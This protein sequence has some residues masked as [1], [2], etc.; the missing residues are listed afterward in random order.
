MNL[1]QMPMKAFFF[2]C[3]V[4]VG[5]ASLVAAAH[6]RTYEIASW[7]VDQRV[8][9]LGGGPFCINQ[10]GGWQTGEPQNMYPFGKDVNETCNS[11]AAG[12]MSSDRRSK[13]GVAACTCR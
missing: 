7:D 4:I 8:K 9:E 11:W 13:S 2:Y 12:Q 5:S 6:A 10:F 1:L 3:A